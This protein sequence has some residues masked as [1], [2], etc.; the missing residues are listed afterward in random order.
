MTATTTA[1]LTDGSAPL[2]SMG[3]LSS[4]AN[5][6]FPK[7]TLVSRNG[8]GRAIAPTDG[9]GFHVAGVANAT[10]DNRTGSEAGGSNDDLDVEVTYGVFGFIL[11]EG[12]ATPAPGDPLY[13]VDNQTVSANPDDGDG[14]DPRGIAGVHVF[15]RDG[16]TFVG[17]G[18]HYLAAAR[19]LALANANADAISNL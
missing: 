5:Q 10:F 1:R 15:T 2:P 13:V 7:G 18:P 3:T 19:A 12:S 11:E 17:V 16:E 14:G 4:A 8:D 6:F 9:D